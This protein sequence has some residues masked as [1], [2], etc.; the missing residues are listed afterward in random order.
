LIVIN[1]C[2]LL[3]DDLR[4]RW[5]DALEE[6]FPR[7]R[8]LAV[9]AK[10]GTG[11]ED[12]FTAMTAT[13]PAI[14]PTME[15]DYATYAEGEALLGW[16]NCTARVVA[17]MPVDG[18]GLLLDLAGAM[19]E[20][21]EERGEEIAH[22][23]MTLDAEDDAGSLSVVSLVSSAGEPDLR[24]SL[25]DRTDG[26]CLVVNLRAETDPER[27]FAVMTD[28][29]SITAARHGVRIDVEH[30]ER[31]RPAPPEPTH[32]VTVSG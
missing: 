21:F 8:V 24:E 2:D 16:L 20:A 11:L 1:K 18:N 14:R 19:R 28:A 10:E 4:A 5:R 30:V 7:A 27:L 22:L 17:P 26:G 6:A 31:F 9:S 13:T 23:K 12:W 32:R 3:A 25:L 29:F 15:L